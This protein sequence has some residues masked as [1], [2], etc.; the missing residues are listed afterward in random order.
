MVSSEQCMN[1]CR[2]GCLPSIL[3]NHFYVCKLI[4]QDITSLIDRIM[5]LLKLGDIESFIPVYSI[6]KVSW[7]TDIVCPGVGFVGATL[8]LLLP[9]LSTGTVK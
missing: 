5:F 2:K 3:C 7:Y 4:C 6:A 1:T 9:R 8:Y